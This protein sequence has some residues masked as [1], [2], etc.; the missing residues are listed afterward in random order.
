MESMKQIY[1][2]L[3]CQGFY[4]AS[5]CQEWTFPTRVKALIGSCVEIPCTYHPPGTSDTY[6]TVWYL[7]RHLSTD[8]EI[9]NTKDLSPIT[10]KYKDR[11]SLV[12]GNNSCALRIDRVGREDDGKYYP[13]I[14]GD[15][16]VNAYK[17]HSR[18][19]YL[20]VSDKVNIQIYGSGPLKEGEATAI[21][22]SA[23]HTCPSSPPSL[24]WNKPGQVI[25]QSVEISGGSWREESELTYIPTYVDDGSRVQCTATYPN[26]LFAQTSAIL[27]INYSP[28]NVTVTIIGMDEVMEGTNVTLQYAP[29]GVRVIV[30]NQSDLICD[31][32]SSRPNVTHYTWMKNRTILYGTGKTLTLED[33]EESSGQYSCIAHNRVG[34]STSEE[35]SIK[36]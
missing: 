14:T 4:L 25:N 17:I 27:S 23:D 24:H 6:G 8:P 22:C 3:I 11:T 28:K 21:R 10:P 7:Y 5:L 19:V 33:N 12:P 13:G 34:N 18:Y 35:I 16:S 2:L 26:D 29:T 20:D 9:L 36:R 15:I 31:F 32:L 1:L 30:V